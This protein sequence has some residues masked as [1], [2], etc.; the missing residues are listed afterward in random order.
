MV[1]QQL[2]RDDE[3]QND[4][5]QIQMQVGN[6]NNNVEGNDIENQ[7]HGIHP[8]AQNE[9]RNINI[10]N[11]QQGQRSVLNI[12]PTNNNDGIANNNNLHQGVQ[13]I[14]QN[15]ENQIEHLLGEG[16]PQQS[17]NYMRPVNSQRSDM[18]RIGVISNASVNQ[19][20]NN[21]ENPNIEEDISNTDI[22]NI[23]VNE[24]DNVSENE[25][26]AENISSNGEI[27]IGDVS[28]SEN[29]SW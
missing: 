25:D 2:A 17:Q 22:E 18:V 19:Q 20:D 7:Q 15:L 1:A 4:G 26:V 27:E 10:H 23:S 13:N 8:E 12:V 6:V 16:V 29:E 24:Q 5:G 14:P 21:M 28:D 3:E 11:I 9:P